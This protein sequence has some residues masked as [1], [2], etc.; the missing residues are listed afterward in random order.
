MSEHAADLLISLVGG[1]ALLISLVA[2]IGGFLH[3]R[4]E[5]LLTHA[6]RMK[7]L[8]LG[9]EIPDHAATAQIKAAFGNLASGNEGEPSEALARKCFSTALW[10]AFWGFVAGSQGGWINPSIAIAI[11]ASVGAIGVTG[12]VCGTVLAYRS[13]TEPSHRPVC[14]HVTDADTFDVVSR[15]G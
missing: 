1:G 4:R 11:A 7:A 2:I 13:P 14:K 8:D 5:R 3:Y 15:R 12:M 9:R 6:E 10:V